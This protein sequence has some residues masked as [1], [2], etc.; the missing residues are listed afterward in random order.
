MMTPF[1]S[2]TNFVLQC[3]LQEGELR[4]DVLAAWTADRAEADKWRK[5]AE[6]LASILESIRDDSYVRQVRDKAHISSLCIHGEY[7][8][9]SC[10]DC[11]EFF[12][13]SALAAFNEAKEG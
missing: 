1:E 9:Q 12:I 8:G 5:V 13:Q 6:G 7:A 2:L 3:S 11:L 4:R 10:F